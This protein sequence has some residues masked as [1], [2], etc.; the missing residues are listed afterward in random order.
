MASD[1]LRAGREQRARASSSEGE[2][3]LRKAIEIAQ[4]GDEFELTVP[5]L[6]R[7]HHFRICDGQTNDLCE[8]GTATYFVI[9]FKDLCDQPAHVRGGFRTTGKQLGLPKVHF[10]V[11]ISGLISFAVGLDILELR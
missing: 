9:F 6:A 2:S 7:Q 11:A 4:E 5:F 1:S 3:C 8:S 10:Q